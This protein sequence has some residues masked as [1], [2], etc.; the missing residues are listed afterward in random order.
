MEKL[1]TF[2][3]N[4]GIVSADGSQDFQVIAKN[5]EEAIK[6]FLNGEAIISS[7]EVEV[8]DLDPWEFDDIEES[9]ISEV[10]GVEVCDKIRDPYV[11]EIA[12]LKGHLNSVRK[13]FSEDSNENQEARSFYLDTQW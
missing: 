13:V 1:K 4:R 3:I 8:M 12:R 5:K 10:E 9:P 2:T 11:E 6:M 7:S